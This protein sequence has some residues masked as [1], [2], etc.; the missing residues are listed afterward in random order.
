MK[1][2]FRHKLR[3]EQKFDGLDALRAA[4]HQDIEAAR[5]YFANRS[6]KAN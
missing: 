3:D 4:I 1:V 2:V 6:D 5:A